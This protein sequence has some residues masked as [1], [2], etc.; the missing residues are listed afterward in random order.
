MPEFEPATWY[1]VTVRCN[2]EHNGPADA[3]PCTNYARE[4]EVNPVYSNAGQPN[5]QCGPCGKKVEILS[6]VR[7]DPQP[8]ES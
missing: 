2:T 1:S 8:E 3:P 5:I 7:L 4:W 6:A